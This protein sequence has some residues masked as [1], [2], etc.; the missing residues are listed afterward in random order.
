[1]CALVKMPCMQS[2]QVEWLSSQPRHQNQ[3]LHNAM[4]TINPSI[5]SVPACILAHM[6]IASYI[7]WCF[8]IHIVGTLHIGASIRF[9]K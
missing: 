6:A 3:L 8:I 7:I 1:V 2:D 5:L 9:V 4:V